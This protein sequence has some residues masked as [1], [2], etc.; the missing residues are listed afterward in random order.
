M[1]CD[2]EASTGIC[3]YITR[4]TGKL[5]FNGYWQHPCPHGNDRIEHE[6]DYA[7]PLVQ[8]IDENKY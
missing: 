5:S 4:G 2:C 6:D 8:K 3:G 7:T 1:K